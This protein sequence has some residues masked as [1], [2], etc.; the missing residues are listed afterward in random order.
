M[1]WQFATERC[2]SPRRHCASGHGHHLKHGTVAALKAIHGGLPYVGPEL[3]SRLLTDAKG[4]AL[5]PMRAAKLQ[6]ALSCRE[7]QML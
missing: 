5:L 6:D 2:S 7:K 1:Q 3:A 4:G